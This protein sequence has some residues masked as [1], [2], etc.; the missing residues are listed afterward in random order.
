MA[1]GGGRIM[2]PGEGAHVLAR[3]VYERFNAKKGRVQ[4]R[5]QRCGRKPWKVA[6]DVGSFL[7]QRLRQ[8]R[9]QVVCTAT[10]LQ[11]DVYKEKGVKLSTSAVRK[12]LFSKDYRWR[13]RAQKRKYDKEDSA[14]RKAFGGRYKNM[15]TRAIGERITLAMDGVVLTVPPS[16]P[17]DRKN[18]CMHRD[19]MMY[20]PKSEAACPARWRCEVCRP[21]AHWARAPFVGRHFAS[22]LPG[23]RVPQEPQ[24]DG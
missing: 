15:S 18:F 6:Q 22:W 12:H 16:D 8:K 1:A 21:G 20:R 10:T 4:Y 13:S 14:E 2:I 7:V 23:D 3:R 19:T 11:A 17:V 5:F 24:T 9:R